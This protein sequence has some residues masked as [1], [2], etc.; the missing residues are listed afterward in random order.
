MSVSSSSEKAIAKSS[1]IVHSLIPIRHDWGWQEVLDCPGAQRPEYCHAMQHSRH[2]AHERFR[3][4]RRRD[5]TIT[6]K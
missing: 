6:T 2:D 3:Q 5:A 1:I 4:S